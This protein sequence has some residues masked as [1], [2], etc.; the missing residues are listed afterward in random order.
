MAH[1][2]SVEAV[3]RTLQDIR[4]CFLPFGGL[5]VVFSGDFR[6][7]L[8]VVE[9]GTRAD[10][11]NACLQKSYL[12]RN[13]RHLRLT[14][15]MRVALGGGEEMSSFS[16]NLLA[17]GEFSLQFL[18]RR[19]EGGFCNFQSDSM[20]TIYFCFITMITFSHF[21]FSFAHN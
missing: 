21:T 16:A 6:Q 7:I 3:D 11:V 10:E 1:K 9:R 12:W 8:P 13:I 19:G 4:D 20:L 2:K 18:L 17:I 14:R 15:N 5:T